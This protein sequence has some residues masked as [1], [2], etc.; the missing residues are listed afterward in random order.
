MYQTDFQMEDL[1]VQMGEFSIE[2]DSK[3]VA[4]GKVIKILS[5]FKKII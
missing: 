1:K 5:D 4:I 2:V 3:N